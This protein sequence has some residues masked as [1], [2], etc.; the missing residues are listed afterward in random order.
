MK[1][2]SYENEF[3]LHKNETVGGTHFHMD[4]FEQTRVETKANGLFKPLV[5]FALSLLRFQ[6]HHRL[7]RNNK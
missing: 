7:P 4:G 3:D 1:D 2:L 6:L 5:H